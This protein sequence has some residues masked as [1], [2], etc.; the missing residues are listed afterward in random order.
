MDVEYNRGAYGKEDGIKKMD[1]NPITVDLIVRKRGY[2]INHGFTYLICIEMKK[3]TN[4]QG[5]ENDE[6]RLNKMCSYEYRFCYSVGY[7]ILINM[8]KIV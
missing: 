5:C 3:S 6:T 1:G 8:E 2:N 7:M 4:R